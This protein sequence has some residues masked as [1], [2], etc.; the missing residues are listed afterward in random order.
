MRYSNILQTIGR[1]PVVRINRLSPKNVNLFVKIEAF[2]PL[3]S[4][5]DRLAI[6]IIEDAERKG[7]LK[8]GQTVVE[9]T[10]GNTGI[11]LAMVCAAKGYPFVAVMS[12]SFSVERRRLMRILGAK[13]ILT[14]AAE[15]GTGMVRKAKKLS[16]EKGWFLADQFNNPANP[17]Y[18]RNT[19]GPEILDAFRGDRLDY[20]VTG[21]GT[22]GTL[23]GA[24]EMIKLAR[25]DCKI[26]LVEPEGAALVSGDS[27]NPHKI[28]GWTPDFIPTVLNKKLPD[29]ILKVN[30][31]E[32]VECARNL[33]SKEGILCG[34][35]S[36]ATF[37]GALKIAKEAPV[38]SN[39]LAMLPDTGER[40]LS[41]IL[42]EGIK[43]ESDE[44]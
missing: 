30:D 34:I 5:K 8:P 17:E 41:T 33:A 16:E 43:V 22:G 2:N 24:G 14:P 21:W 4:V 26:I 6:A 36:G 25:P 27:F 20:W 7:T 35:S 44:L 31:V 18:H 13:V 37:A 42:F 28:Q 39:I 40:Y 11:A 12:D 23:T 1:T 32:A 15:R 3:S 19:T 9:A 10:S 38:G 29:R